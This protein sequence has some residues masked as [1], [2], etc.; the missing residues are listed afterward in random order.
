MWGLGCLLWEV[1][2]GALPRPEELKS[3]GRMSQ[4]VVKQYVVLVRCVPR[5]PPPPPSGLTPLLS[6]HHHRCAL[7][8]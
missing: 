1:H 2:N 4:K 3:M 5:K 6:Q 8:T 7:P